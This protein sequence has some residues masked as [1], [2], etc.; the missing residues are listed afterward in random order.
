MTTNSRDLISLKIVISMPIKMVSVKAKWFQIMP[1]IL[2]CHIV[3]KYL[4]RKN[5]VGTTLNS[6]ILGSLAVKCKKKICILKC[7]I[8]FA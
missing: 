1:T 2:R 7:K 5:Y 3:F 4:I 6:I 8:F